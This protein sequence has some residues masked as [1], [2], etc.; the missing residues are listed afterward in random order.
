MTQQQQSPGSN[1]STQP[2]V[3]GAHALLGASIICRDQL[4]HDVLPH[5]HPE[6]WRRWPLPL[7]SVNH[8]LL[9]HL[10]LIG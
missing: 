9:L 3:M 7:A 2:R 4:L 10:W 1:H 6:Q 8:L 5:L